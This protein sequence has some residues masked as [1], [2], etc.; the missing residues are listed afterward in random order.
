METKYQEKSN[1]IIVCGSGASATNGSVSTGEGG[2]AIK[3]VKG[4]VGVIQIPKPKTK[5]LYYIFLSC[6]HD[7]TC[8]FSK[9]ISE[10]PQRIPRDYKEVCTICHL[11]TIC[12]NKDQLKHIIPNT[13]IEFINRHNTIIA[14]YQD[15]EKL[16]EHCVFIVNYHR[17]ANNINYFQL[18]YAKGKG[19]EILVLLCHQHFGLY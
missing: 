7:A 3:D 15:M 16:Y 13:E 18:G 10:I 5:S 17:D 14:A 6:E 1:R 8:K 4:N 11:E 9:T 12:A 19:I 2:I